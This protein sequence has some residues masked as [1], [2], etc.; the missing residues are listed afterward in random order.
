MGPDGRGE[1]NCTLSVN[2]EFGVIDFAKLDLTLGLCD[3]PQVIMRC[4]TNLGGYSIMM[5]SNT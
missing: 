1:D 5:K 4:K 3:K 2:I